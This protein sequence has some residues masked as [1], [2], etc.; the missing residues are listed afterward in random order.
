MVAGQSDREKRVP[1]LEVL[2]A[3]QLTFR[4][5]LQALKESFPQSLSNKYVR[6]QIFIFL[7]VLFL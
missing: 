3:S 1:E 2:L 7:K 6:W 4:T 5:V